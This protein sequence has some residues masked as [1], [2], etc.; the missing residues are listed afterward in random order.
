VTGVAVT[1]DGRFAVSASEDRTLKVWDVATGQHIRTL[2][3]HTRP[4]RGVAVTADGRFAVSYDKMLKVWDLASG[5]LLATLEPHA[6]VACCA[7]M[8]DGKTLL[9]GDRAGALHI[10]DWR[11]GGA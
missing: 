3:G 1:A 6:F 9:A 8:P 2:D 10:L 7:I 4:A 5:H 11:N